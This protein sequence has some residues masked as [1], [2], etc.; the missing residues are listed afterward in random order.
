MKTSPLFAVLFCLISSVI[1][2]Q[3]K[4]FS[5]VKTAVAEVRI[6]GEWKQLN[7]TDDSGQTYLKNNEDVVI[8][9]A[10][11]PKKAYSFFETGKSDFD[12]VKAFY[13]WD[14]DYRKEGNFKT[15]KIKENAKLQYVIWKFNDGKLDNVFLFGS[16]KDN[17]INLLVF[18][19][20]WTEAQKIEFLE[21]L[22]KLNR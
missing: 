19:D 5:I 9:V 12:N 6:P 13:K 1:F 18:T 21:N 2:A 4:E 16:V 11:N 14:S 10:M 17:F 8:A 22:Y 7:T 15:N 20:N 3:N